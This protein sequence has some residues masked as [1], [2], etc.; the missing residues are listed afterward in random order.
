MLVTLDTPPQAKTPIKHGPDL[1]S[2][3]RHQ[4]DVQEQK[5]QRNYAE[6]MARRNDILEKYDD[7]FPKFKENRAKR[8]GRAGRN[9]K[10]KRL[11]FV[12]E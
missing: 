1:G 11:V 6:L 12:A 3:K 7:P 5:P 8:A 4:P 10:A 2:S 9:G